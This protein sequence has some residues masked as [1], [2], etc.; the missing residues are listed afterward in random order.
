MRLASLVRDGY[1]Q[2]GYFQAEKV[3]KAEDFS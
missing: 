2:V 1:I 3:T